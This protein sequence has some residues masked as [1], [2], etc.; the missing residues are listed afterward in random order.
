M[1]LKLEKKHVTDDQEIAGTTAKSDKKGEE[2]QLSIFQLEDP[3]LERIRDDIMRLDI[4]TL[5]PV[6]AL[7][8][9]NEIKNL[10]KKY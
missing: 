4:N 1:F 10:L 7:M 8:K 6:E 2:I 5:T 9:L 3:L